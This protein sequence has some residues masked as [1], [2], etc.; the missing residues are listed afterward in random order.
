MYKVNKSEIRRF[1]KIVTLNQSLSHFVLVYYRINKSSLVTCFRTKWF[2]SN[3]FIWQARVRP[4]LILP[5]CLLFTP[6]YA[7]PPSPLTPI[8]AR[9]LIVIVIFLFLLRDEK[10]AD[11][12]VFRFIARRNKKPKRDDSGSFNLVLDKKFYG[13]SQRTLE[14][15]LGD[16]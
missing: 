10:Q 2:S 4:A 6:G 5:C 16:L 12:G 7:E 15:I 13:V 14:N 9:A 1:L 3:E 8:I 11:G